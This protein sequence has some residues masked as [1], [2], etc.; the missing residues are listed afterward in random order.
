MS[1]N[2]DLLAVVDTSSGSS[3]DNNEGG[4]PSIRSK[5]PRENSPETVF[6]G[7][8]YFTEPDCQYSAFLSPSKLHANENL[9]QFRP[10]ELPSRPAR[11]VDLI[12][13]SPQ[14]SHV[15]NIFLSIMSPVSL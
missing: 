15:Q 13:P 11:G 12:F 10:Q 14:T 5:R 3:E 2:E 7:A 6:P 4:L 1:T 9:I 8:Q